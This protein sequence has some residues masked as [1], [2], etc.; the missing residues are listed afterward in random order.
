VTVRHR[1]G[2]FPRRVWEAAR[3][4][5]SD[6]KGSGTWYLCR[7][8]AGAHERWLRPSTFKER[9]AKVDFATK[10]PRQLTRLGNQGAL[11]TFD[12]T[13]DGKAIV[14]DRSRENSYIVRIDLPK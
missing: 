2:L 6:G 11:G 7:R 9:P 1:I 3:P 10:A 14:F 13:P 4:S 5:S 8:T 12:I